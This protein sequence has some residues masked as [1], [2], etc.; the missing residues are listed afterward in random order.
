MDKMIEIT[1]KLYKLYNGNNDDKQNIIQR[2]QNKD[3]DVN[4]A[5]EIQYTKTSFIGKKKKIAKISNKL[6]YEYILSVKI[7]EIIKSLLP[8]IQSV[9]DITLA[10]IDNILNL[11]SPEFTIVKFDFH[12]Y[13]AT[14]S[15]E[16]IY[17]HH[18]APYISND[19]KTLFENYIKAVPYCKAGL[20]PSNAFAEIMSN[21][22][23]DQIRIH[24]KKYKLANCY[25]YVDD[26]LLV[27]N[28]NISKQKIVEEIEF[29]LKKVYFDDQNISNK[30]KCKIYFDGEK[31]AHLNN[32]L[33]PLS[34]NN[35]GYEYNLSL[36]NNKLKLEIGISPWKINYYT[37]KINSLVKQNYKDVE[38]LRLLL[39]AHTRRFIVKKTCINSANKNISVSI[40]QSNKVLKQHQ[41]IINKKTLDF[42]KNVIIETFESQNIPLPYYLKDK[43]INSG[44]NLYHN[45]MTNKS[46]V[47][48]PHFG[49]SRQK[50][51]S[52]LKAMTNEKLDNLSYSQL[53][54]LFAK[55][56][57]LENDL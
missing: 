4:F 21:K 20:V 15:T 8:K 13:F 56:Y 24:F 45:F 28:M 26:F 53:S 22:L 46:I 2:L 52:M 30:N 37:N 38:K 40:I 31:F 18:I 23:K 29:C 47:L 7:N 55:Y 57:Q 35:L 25:H 27:F 11:K 42:M 33:L 17:K 6:S 54:L 32:D 3:Y 14:L 34:F 36:K 9:N 49:Y 50:L 19:D 16:Y 10:L 1:N 48:N 39:F 51:V 12:N 41:N 44:Y 43:N 5:D